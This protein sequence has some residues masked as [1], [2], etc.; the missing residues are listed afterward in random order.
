MSAEDVHYFMCV[1]CRKESSTTMITNESAVQFSK[2]HQFSISIDKP[3]KQLSIK[4]IACGSRWLKG[5]MILQAG[6]RKQNKTKHFSAVLIV[7]HLLNYSL[8]PVLH[9]IG[10][11]THCAGCRGLVPSTSFGA[12]CVWVMVLQHDFTFTT[13]HIVHMQDQAITCSRVWS[14]SI[15]YVLGSKHGIVNHVQITQ[16]KPH[17]GGGGFPW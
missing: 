1:F 10:R 11:N 15:L 17:R 8:V 16:V 14:I 2:V 6:N 5:V 9:T 12:T 7:I 4:A 3:P 13:A